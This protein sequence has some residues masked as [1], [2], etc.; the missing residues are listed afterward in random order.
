MC[1]GLKVC[2]NSGQCGSAETVVIVE[3]L[4][5]K[6]GTLVRNFE[7]NGKKGLVINWSATELL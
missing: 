1:S 4:F 7:K 6:T 5:W 3:H 2:L